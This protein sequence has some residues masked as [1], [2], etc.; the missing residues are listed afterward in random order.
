MYIQVKHKEKT[1]YTPST[2]KEPIVKQ[3][4]QYTKKKGTYKIYCYF[5]EVNEKKYRGGKLSLEQLNK[6]LGEESTDYPKDLK[7]SF[8]ENFEIV[9]TKDYET[10]LMNLINKLKITFSLRNHEEAVLKHSM[11]VNKI[12]D[13]IVKNSKEN[14]YLSYNDIIS[15]TEDSFKYIFTNEYKKYTDNEKYKKLIY[16]KY[17]KEKGMESSL[18]RRIF[19]I[20]LKNRNFSSIANTIN[21]IHRKYYTNRANAITYIYPVFCLYG[22]ECSPV[23]KELITEYMINDG[24]LYHNDEFCIKNIT[25]KITYY[26]RYNPRKNTDYSNKL[27]ENQIII[28]DEKN[29]ENFIYSLDN[30]KEYTIY[31]FYKNEQLD[32]KTNCH[33]INIP[34]LVDE[35]DNDILNILKL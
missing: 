32:V 26:Q 28:I 12:M 13:T 7:T 6:Y 19:A 27:L 31:N 24:Y 2:L 14:R 9:F 3:F 22:G 25:D 21:K 1:N 17:F 4:I 29:I 16:N 34:I 5:G 15:L 8:L 30:S 18:I 11:I 33:I 10:E 23:K 35:I 20:E